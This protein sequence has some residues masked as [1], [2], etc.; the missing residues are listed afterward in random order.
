[1]TVLRGRLAPAVALSLVA[2]VVAAV[3]GVDAAAGAPPARRD[4]GVGEHMRPGKPSDGF[5][6]APTAR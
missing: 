3:I 4:G 1:V 5:Q 2:T 6:P